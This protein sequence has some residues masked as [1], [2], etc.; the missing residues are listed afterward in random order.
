MLLPVEGGAAN[1]GRVE[2]FH[3]RVWQLVC[4]SSWDLRDGDVVCRELG[5]GYAVRVVGNALFG[6]G[7]GLQWKVDL[8]CSDNATGLKYCRY[9]S[10]LTMK[11]CTHS[12]D[13]G[14]ICSKTSE[15]IIL[16]H[17]YT[18]VVLQQINTLNI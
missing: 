4:D 11:P 3:E 16:L 15:N 8:H 17:C 2:V 10:L 1:E 14:A 18:D 12:E 7:T 5:Y 13:A 9:N 6:E